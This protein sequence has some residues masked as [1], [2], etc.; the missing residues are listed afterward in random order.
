VGTA[1]AIAGLKELL[2]ESAG[3]DREAMANLVDVSHD[4]FVAKLP[5][6]VARSMSVVCPKERLH[7]WAERAW[8]NRLAM[9]IGE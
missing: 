3:V 5:P 7:G 9:K 1:T 8:Q 2:D 4:S 6:L